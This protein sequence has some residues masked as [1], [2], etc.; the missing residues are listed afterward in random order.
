MVDIYRFNRLL[1]TKPSERQGKFQTVSKNAIDMLNLI[2]KLLLTAAAT[3]FAAWISPGVHISSF[4]SAI[5]VA[6]VLTLLNIFVK[7]ILEFISIPVTFLTLGLFLLVINAVIILIASYLVG[8]FHVSGFW[9]AFL[10]SIIF[11]VISWILESIF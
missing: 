4:G 11:T 9:S 2:V 5:V 1:T 7:P 10:F 6:I 8:T 3:Y